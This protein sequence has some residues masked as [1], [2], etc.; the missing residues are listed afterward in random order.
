MR[1]AAGWDVALC[2]DHFGHGYMTAKEVIRLGEAVEPYGLAW[3]EDPMPW[4]DIDGHK[5]SD[6]RNL[7]AYL[8]RGEE[9][10]LWDGFRELDRAA[11]GRY[12]PSGS[13]DVWRNARDQEDRRLC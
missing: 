13:A 12:H 1:E 9:L 5:R 4:W 10:Y 3:M 7:G 2:T 6:R 8:R 11:S